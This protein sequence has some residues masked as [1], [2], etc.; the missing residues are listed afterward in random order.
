MSNKTHQQK[1]PDEPYQ[2]NLELKGSQ[3]SKLNRQ[4]APTRV[5]ASS[6]TAETKK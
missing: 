3:M 5:L 2:I 6:A 1:S 4:K